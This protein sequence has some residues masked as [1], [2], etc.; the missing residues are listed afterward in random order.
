MSTS[1]KKEFR[2]HTDRPL[3]SVILRTHA[4]YDG[5][6]ARALNSIYEQDI[7]PELV[8]VI[9]TH[10]G[11]PT[12]ELLT[13]LDELSEP[14]METKFL[15]TQKQW[16]YYCYPSNMAIVHS[17]GAYIAHLDADNEWKPEHLSSLLE[18][19]R[20]ARDGEGWPHFAYS[21]REYVRDPGADESLPIGPSPLVPWTRRNMVWL[22]EPHTNFID[23]SDFLVGRGSLYYVA[24]LTGRMW[25]E[26]LRR[27]GD[28]ELMTRFASC[29][30][31]GRAV[32]IVSHIYHWHE[33]NLQVTR[34]PDVGV[35]PLPIEQYDRLV[36][37]G[38]IKED[39]SKGETDA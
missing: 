7:V 35:R 32:D 38:K 8:E 16:G 9:I 39:S 13:Y 29:G 19:L 22:Q 24:E 3:I 33:R 31:R 1:K 23:S 26:S 21:R 6:M 11:I 34:P 25:N 28:W 5:F 12:E 2:N 37:G 30:L 15:G 4:D 27:F 17:Q 14:P 18:A 10:D 36:D 20:E